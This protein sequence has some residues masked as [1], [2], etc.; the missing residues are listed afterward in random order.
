MRLR[1]NRMI[2][3]IRD[4]WP[5]RGDRG[6]T[7]IL[8]AMSM[9]VLMGFAAVAVDSG[10]LYSDRRQQQ[11][12]ADVGALAAVQFAKTT[13]PTTNCGA[14]SG[15]D[16]AACRGAEE[17]IDVIEGTL[18]GRYALVGDWDTCVDSGKPA[19]YTQSSTISDC[20]SFTANLQKARV[21]LPGTDVD[22]S[23][24]RVIG[25][26]TVRVG[27]FAEAKLDLSL[28]GGP[29]PFAVGP[30]AGS[31]SQA[32][33]FAQSSGNLDID[34]CGSS[35]EGNFGKLNLRLYGNYTMGTPQICSGITAA[36]MAVNIV[37]GADHAMELTGVSPGIVNDD[38]NCPIT[39]NPVD[40][41]ITWTGN[42]SGA[43][44]DGFF[45]GIATPNV[46]GRLLCKGA[47]S[48]GPGNEY[49]DQGFV[50]TEWDDINNYLDESVDHTPLW[51]YIVPGAISEVIPGGAC[52]PGLGVITNRAEMATC[53]DGWKA[54]TV[55]NGT[56]TKA[57]FEP[58]LSLSPRFAAVPIIHADPGTGLGQYLITNF[59][60]TYIETVY[61]KCNANT[62]D[63]VHSPGE[64]KDTDQPLACPNPLTADIS[65]CGWPSNGNKGIEAVSSFVLTLDMLDPVI[66]DHFPFTPGTIIYNLSK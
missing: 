6:A 26:N 42:A 43:M 56:H 5:A 23:F 36:R 61:F 27:A 9:V 29:I 13:L 22:T 55:V 24:A 4:S 35:D 1:V 44:Q 48:T 47:L 20:I 39:S 58:T 32:C 63:I 38:T 30:G 49:A 33:F 54:W 12:A 51:Y 66:A 16:Y 50:S 11:S 14:L 60:P 21:V 18:P 25:V 10:I 19:E 40:Q 62:C 53:L 37:M 15:I 64:N 45:D 3:R 2:T 57:L 41:L 65:S 7:A 59:L 52:A 31:S 46:E 8:V 17:A 34:T 28:K